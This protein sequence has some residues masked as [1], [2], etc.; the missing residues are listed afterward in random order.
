MGTK[1]KA[2]NSPKIVVLGWDAATWDLLTPWVE[3]GLLPNLADLMEK[4]AYGSL[5][6]TPL[7]VSPA[8]WT[9]IITGKNPAK[10]AVFDWFSRKPDSYDVSYVHTGMIKTKTVWDYLND[11]GLRIGVFNLPMIYPA[12][13]IDGFMLS[14]LAAPNANAANFGYPRDL[15]DEL[16]REFGP[17][18]NAETVVYQSGRE[19]E[20]LDD[21][22]SWTQY[23]DKVIDYLKTHHACDVYWLVFMQTDH[24]QHKF[25]RYMDKAFPGYDADVDSQF[26]DGILQS[27]QQLDMMLG[28]WILTANQDVHFIVLS[29][30]G[31]GPVH[32]VMYINRWLREKGYLHLRKNLTTQIK[33][34]IA[35]L[36]LVSR[37]Y[38]FVSRLGLGNIVNLVSKPVRNKVINSF[39]TFTDIDWDRTKAYSR[40]SFGQIF[41]NLEGREPHGIVTQGKEYEDLVK[42]LLKD[43]KDIV[44]PDYGNAL[45]TDIKQPKDVY[46]GK[47]LSQA[48][49]IMFSIYDYRYQSSVKMGLESSSILGSSEYNDSSSHRPEGVFVMAG[50]GILNS[51][52]IDGA[53]A[54]DILPTI[55]SLLGIPI[56][57]DMDGKPIMEALTPEK[58]Q[59]V[60]WVSPENE[61][62]QDSD[63][64]DL[65]S[66]ELAE[67][68][69]RL[70]DLGYLG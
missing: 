19:Q 43:L 6:S 25:W 1:D 58:Q 29:D 50:P 69:N 49:D 15:I 61:A 67:I 59:E 42:Q 47:Y 66:D 8:A 33:Y 17:Y 57:T 48:A 32:G 64:P 9:S 22:K 70:R 26:E 11:A 20:F 13:E 14:G 46:S 41:I 38:N 62:F 40:G 63:S 2:G 27:F 31:A 51:D 68:E 5:Q 56:P 12:S 28:E 4:G 10:H 7:P 39:I 65:N 55:L 21:V 54:T 30:H 23:Q 16:E 60:R 18:L 36:N 52:K 37:V 53:E 3:K 34:F 35:R 24:M 45:I 44:H